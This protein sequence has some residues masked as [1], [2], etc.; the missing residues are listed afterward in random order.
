MQGQISVTTGQGDQ[1]ASCQL[2]G[3]TDSLSAGQ[4]VA[5]T[6]QFTNSGALTLDVPVH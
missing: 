1:A 6:F 5:L 2:V 3:L 4:R